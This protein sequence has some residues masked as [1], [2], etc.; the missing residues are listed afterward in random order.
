MPTPLPLT[1]STPDSKHTQ[2]Y[3]STTT[4]NNFPPKPPLL[5]LVEG[6]AGFLRHSTRRSTSGSIAATQSQSNSIPLCHQKRNDGGGRPLT[7]QA[8]THHQN[9]PLRPQ[10]N[11]SRIIT[12]PGSRKKRIQ[13]R[14]HSLQDRESGDGS[15]HTC[16]SVGFIGRAD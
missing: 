16:Q 9:H 12:C 1:F 10:S 4:S 2:E 8:N 5:G 11:S 13:R 7:D 3:P 15:G 14:S 6:E